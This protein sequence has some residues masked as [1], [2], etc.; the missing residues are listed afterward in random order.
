[1]IVTGPTEHY[2]KREA[3][4]FFTGAAT[5]PVGALLTFSLRRRNRERR[6][7]ALFATGGYH[8]EK[9]AGPAAVRRDV[10]NRR[11]RS[12]RIDRDV[13]RS[14]GIR[15]DR[16]IEPRRD[17]RRADRDVHGSI[18]H[19]DHQRRQGDEEHLHLQGAAR[20]AAGGIFR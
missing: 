7:P 5:P 16:R 19:P 11:K 4:L 3:A 17:R 1:M 8:R 13:A 14:D 15:V 18:P 20:G 9:N 2:T 12:T 6:Y 10:V